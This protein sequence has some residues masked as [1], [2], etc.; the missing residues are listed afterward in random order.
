MKLKH[1]KFVS[2]VA[3][4]H[5][6]EG[7]IEGFLTMLYGAFSENFEKFEIICVNDSSTDRSKQII[8]SFA[9][10]LSD[11]MISMVNTGFYQ[12]A[13]SSMLAGLDLAI[14]DFVFEFDDTVIDYTPDLIMQCYD[15]CVRGFDIVSCGNERRRVSSRIFY[16]IYNRHSGTQYEL[17]SETFRVI[18]RR[19][20][21]RVYSMSPNPIYRKALYR[22]CG[23]KTD[24]LE[25]KGQKDIAIR[26]RILKNPQDT[27][28]T[29]LILF[30]D[31][32]YKSAL[33]LT[34]FMMFAT[35]GS[36]GYVIV[37][38]LIG[39]PIE[40][41][42]T[43]MA[44]LSGS[45]LGIFAILVV[46]IKYMSVILRLVFQRQRYMLESVEKLTG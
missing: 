19:A 4:V 3:Y 29:S 1:Q 33:I 9:S 32:A 21:N 13:E 14:G 31:V 36:V 18:S 35:L 39:D 34:L 17:K 11:C 26:R 27:A 23:L 6:A 40:G 25:Y 2:A 16:S 45:F 46:L 20:I 38:Y 44:L 22:N 7:D 41:Y 30:T 10:T 37:I 15:R 28:L 42:T 43:M 5:N 24:Y 8:R 12:G